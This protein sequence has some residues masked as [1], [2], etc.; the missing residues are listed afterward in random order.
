LQNTWEKSCEP[1]VLRGD[2]AVMRVSL[3]RY[4]CA[5]PAA[6]TWANLNRTQVTILRFTSPRKHLRLRTTF[7]HVI[8]KTSSSSWCFFNSPG[9]QTQTRRRRLGSKC[10]TIHDHASSSPVGRRPR[11]GG[12]RWCAPGTLFGTTSPHNR[13]RAPGCV[14]AVALRG[15][16]HR[17]TSV[18]LQALNAALQP[19]HGH[20]RNTSPRKN[21]SILS[22]GNHEVPPA[23]PRLVRP[24]DPSRSSRHARSSPPS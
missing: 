3:D 21:P 18:T 23:D 7:S 19:E 8:C 22:T 9:K 16:Q 11:S 13:P 12:S 24:P 4:G 17:S 20:R 5:G 10:R 14:K 15:G 6:E 2:C 1:Q